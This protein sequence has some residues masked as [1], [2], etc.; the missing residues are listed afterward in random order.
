MA[1]ERRQLLARD[2]ETDR[3]RAAGGGSKPV[4][5]TARVIDAIHKLMEKETAG[6]PIRGVKW[7]RKTTGKI[8]GQLKRWGSPSA[9]TPL[10]GYCSG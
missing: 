2:V 4:E 5:K 6:D 3:V 9:A 7:T 1:K 8:A 10:D